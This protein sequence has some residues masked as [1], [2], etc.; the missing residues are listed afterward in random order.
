MVLGLKLEPRPVPSTNE[1]PP[2]LVPIFAGNVEAS[3]GARPTR[4]A[5]IK[6]LKDPADHES[7]EQFADIY[8]RLMR[9]V[10]L[11]SG[12][13]EPEAQEVVQETLLSVARKMP[14][15]K[16]DPKAGSFKSWLLTLIYW[17][18]AD[19]KRRKARLGAGAV[20]RSANE[21]SPKLSSDETARTSTIERIPDPHASELTAIWD[22]EWEKHLLEAA[23]DRVRQRI[24][25]EQFQ[26][27]D[28]HV[29]SGWPA[30]KV[31]KKLGVSLAQVYVAKYRVSRLLKREIEVLKDALS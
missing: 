26:L 21:T 7:W 10:A 1:T 29:L 18:I 19:A 8:G 17:R 27:F 23:T 22:A 15:F 6:R 31:A 24:D 16:C 14:E 13:N 3:A 4:W 12:L 9:A 2:R 5:L 11:R 30:V 28:F 20:P 25:P